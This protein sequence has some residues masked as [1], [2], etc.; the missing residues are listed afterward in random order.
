MIYWAEVWRD[1]VSLHAAP[2][3]VGPLVEEHLFNQLDAV[4]T[5][6]TLRTAPLLTL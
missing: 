1:R 3:N 2:L 5:S 6:D 4:L